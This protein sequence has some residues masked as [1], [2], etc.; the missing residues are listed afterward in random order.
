ML[1]PGI[2]GAKVTG[3]WRYLGLIAACV[4]LAAILAA[5]GGE[6][7]DAYDRALAL[8]TKVHA[9]EETVERLEERLA[10][11]EAAAAVVDNG[12]AV[13][14]A[15]FAELESSI[16]EALD[17]VAALAAEVDSGATAI[18]EISQGLEGLEA[19]AGE[20][21]KL[22]EFG[23]FDLDRRIK[24]L[25]GGEDN[26]FEDTANLIEESGADVR[27]IG[28][29]E[30]PAVLVLPYPMPEKVLP[31]IVSLHGFGGNSYWQSQYVPLHER[32]NA[33]HFAL[34]LP[35]GT[36]NADGKR[37]WN[38]TDLLSAKGEPAPDDVAYLSALVEEAGQQAAI[39]PVYFFGYSN[40]GFMSYWMACKGLPGLRAVASLAGTSYAD[41][42]ACEGAAPVSVL[43]IHGSA[44]EVVLYSGVVAEPR[45]E[46]DAGSSSYAGGEEMLMR[47]GKRA[48]CEWPQNSDEY[49]HQA[50]LDLDQYVTGPETLVFRP[51]LNC[52]EGISIE[53]WVGLE[54]GHSPGYGDAFVDAL[55]DWLLA[56]E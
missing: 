13:D 20:I 53:L 14:A 24:E 29:D 26:A 27:V 32:V 39:G 40:G 56:Q 35:N 47:W 46:S 9:L 52:P 23:Y 33:G 48:D 25:N 21:A 2:P 41:D 5:C 54:S 15:A 30:R 55:L 37:F 7:S 11:A 43:H 44:D 51:G 45:L 16:V 3:M 34:L 4:L 28:S 38:P 18:E 6:D 22:I 12:G 49:A 50:I 17:Q 8:E 19:A 31:L 42:A 1:P 10:A 36:V